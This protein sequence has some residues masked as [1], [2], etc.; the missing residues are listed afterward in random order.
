M[1]DGW[2]KRLIEGGLR[3]KSEG[4]KGGNSS[5]IWN[6]E[7]FFVLS[8]VCLYDNEKIIQ[9]RGKKC[10]DAKE[11]RQPLERCPWVGKREEDVAQSFLTALRIRVTW[12]AG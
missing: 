5:E 10:D 3:Q 11:R 2:S 9:E 12:K 8:P 1:G 7:I 6:E 4:E